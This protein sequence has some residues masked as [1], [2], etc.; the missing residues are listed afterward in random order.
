MAGEKLLC[1]RGAPPFGEQ[2]TWNES[3]PSFSDP[4]RHLTMAFSSR[5][6]PPLSPRISSLCGLML[7]FF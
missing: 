3:I 4:E 6:L 2:V 1:R 5:P 7:R